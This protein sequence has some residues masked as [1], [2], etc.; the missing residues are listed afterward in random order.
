M[1]SY[2]SAWKIATVV[3]RNSLAQILAVVSTFPRIKAMKAAENAA[4]MMM[5]TILV[6]NVAQ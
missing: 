3:P 1:L 5:M 4:M 2:F 6:W